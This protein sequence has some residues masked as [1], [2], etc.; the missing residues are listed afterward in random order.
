M[1]E[2]NLEQ[3]RITRNCS[4]CDFTAAYED[5]PDGSV[6]YLGI[7]ACA[8]CLKSEITKEFREILTHISN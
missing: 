1:N 6:I 3:N 8:G 4:F 5:F 7:A 2:P